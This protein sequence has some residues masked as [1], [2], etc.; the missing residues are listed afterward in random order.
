MNLIISLFFEDENEE[1]NSEIYFICYR[2]I[3]T[4]ED[5]VKISKLYDADF[6]GRSE[7][8]LELYYK[9]NH[10]VYYKDC[11]GEVIK[12]HLDG[13]EYNWMGT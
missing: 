13:M 4:E 1:S 12:T 9:D 6:L 7:N 2:G 8:F 10:N 3:E 11:E 5:R